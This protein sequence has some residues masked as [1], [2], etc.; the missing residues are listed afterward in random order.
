MIHGITYHERPEV[1]GF[2]SEDA[3]EKWKQWREAKKIAEALS[4]QGR[5]GDKVAIGFARMV[6]DEKF[7]QASANPGRWLTPP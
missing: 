6:A 7:R 5:F 3:F 4:S 2:P 1:R